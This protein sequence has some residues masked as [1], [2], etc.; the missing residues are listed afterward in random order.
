MAFTPP[1]F[2]G[3]EDEEAKRLKAAKLLTLQGAS[4]QLTP[5]STFK[6]AGQLG[7]QVTQGVG[8]QAAQQVQQAGQQAVALTTEQLQQKALQDKQRLA[9]Q[10]LS[11]KSFLSG[12]ERAQGLALSSEARQS[13]E[14]LTSSE[15]SEA[16]RLSKL[17]LET[18]ANLSFLTRKQRE[19]LSSLGSDVKEQIFDSRLQ[20]ER[21]ET[22]RKFS[23]ER[24]LADYAILTAKNEA[25]LRAKADIM[26]LMSQREIQ[27]MGAAEA[28]V[29]E[30]LR[31]SY[32]DRGREL[33]QTSK[34]YVLNIAN[35]AEKKIK[36]K[37]AAAA[38][39]SAIITGVFQVAGAVI[40]AVYT[41]GTGAGVGAAAGF[42]VGSGVG[43]LVDGAT[44]S[45]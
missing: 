24:Q 35:E 6:Q 14:R 8:Q 5:Q 13:Q 38:N 7:A 34:E 29:R 31:A 11:Q 18:D 23:N 1:P 32:A 28:K 30:S 20:F 25:D 12:Q 27:L 42:A 21:D 36:K 41:G 4:G 40:G 44:A 16:K 39:R 26:Q 33:S 10:E 3:Q 19:D 45:S 22:G 9:E 2:P 15:I 17:G 37:K 43:K